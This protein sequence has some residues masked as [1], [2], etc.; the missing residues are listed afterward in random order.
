MGQK[1]NL[2]RDARNIDWTVW[3]NDDGTWNDMKVQIALL[4]DIRQELKRLND[5]LHCPN[6][7]EIPSILRAVKKNTTKKKRP[8]KGKPK[9]RV[10]SNG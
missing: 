7:L 2:S 5:V 1:R 8:A 10:V 6:F 4:N 9:L 3:V